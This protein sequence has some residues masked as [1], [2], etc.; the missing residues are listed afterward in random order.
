MLADNASFA[1]EDEGEAFDFD[2]SGD[3]VPEADCLPPLPPMFLA[4]SAE[5]QY[6]ED[7]SFNT[8]LPA[9]SPADVTVTTST[10]ATTGGAT[11][12]VS[13]GASV[14]EAT[15]DKDA[16]L[17]PPPPPLDDDNARYPQKTGTEIL[18]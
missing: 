18:C 3:D 12:D 5:D 6:E 8:D 16:D 2:D 13:A 15:D 10:P 7:C 9:P 14:P 1:D 4:P 17:P 11:T